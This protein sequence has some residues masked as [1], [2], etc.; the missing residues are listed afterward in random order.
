[1]L[2]CVPALFSRET[3]DLASP[4]ALSDLVGLQRMGLLMLSS[5][6]RPIL[7]QIRTSHLALRLAAPINPKF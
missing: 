4:W 7:N 5:L 3:P 1:M 6:D 2:R